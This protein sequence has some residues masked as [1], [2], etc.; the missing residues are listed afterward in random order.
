MKMI[1]E[2]WKELE[3]SPIHFISQKS[4]KID[5]HAHLST[6]LKHPAKSICYPIISTDYILAYITE[7][8]HGTIESLLNNYLPY[9]YSVIWTP[10]LDHILVT[11]LA[12]VRHP[13]YG[14]IICVRKFVLLC[15]YHLTDYLTILHTFIASAQG[16]AAPRPPQ[17]MHG[18]RPQL[19]LM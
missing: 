10:K 19:I 17:S 4:L 3:N 5:T 7:Y 9:F 18:L 11:V 15:S 2:K 14:T 16:G 13:V 8:N 1:L 6:P 12:F